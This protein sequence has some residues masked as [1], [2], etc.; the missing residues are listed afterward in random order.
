VQHSSLSALVSTEIVST[1]A[2]SAQ[3]STLSVQHASLSAAF[4]NELSVRA[5]SVNALS[6]VVSSNLA[7]HSALSVQHSSLSAAFSTLSVQHSSLSALESALS[8]QV[9]ALSA[10]MTSLMANKA[11]LKGSQLISVSAPASVS[12]MGFSVGAGNTYAF[13]YYIIYTSAAP[14]SGLGL[15]VT[16]PGMTNFAATAEIS[17]GVDGTANIYSGSI[18]T[19][20]D[21]VQAVSCQTS[22]E[23]FYAELYGVCKVSTSGT[24]ALQAFPEVSGAANQIV[25][26]EGTAGAIWRTG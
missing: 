3:V 5:L 9:S 6:A 14:A 8:V 21:R 17:S 7:L 2:L 19:S 11:V 18:T 26:K 13:K 16:F 20:G 24:L 12:A 1:D 23:Q 10:Q 25:I 4:S 15:T 22:T